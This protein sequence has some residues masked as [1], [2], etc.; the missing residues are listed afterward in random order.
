MERRTFLSLF[1]VGIFASSLPVVLAACTA[2]S[3]DAA[4]PPNENTSTTSEQP[5]SDTTASVPEGYTLVGTLDELSAQGSLSTEVDGKPVYVF[6]NPATA[7]IVALNPTCTHKGCAVALAG[8]TFEC[9]CHDSHFDLDGNVTK[10]PAK[11]SLTAYETLEQED[12]LF[13]KVV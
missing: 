8:D 1:G 9:P 2:E 10:G 12:S 13:V 4:S 6:Q 3:D 5:P 11:T 7:A